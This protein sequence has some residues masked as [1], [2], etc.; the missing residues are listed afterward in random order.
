MKLKKILYQKKVVKIM[1]KYKIEKYTRNLRKTMN[2]GT[3]IKQMN[4]ALVDEKFE[5]TEKVNE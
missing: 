5:I 1:D 3:A 4:P 2:V